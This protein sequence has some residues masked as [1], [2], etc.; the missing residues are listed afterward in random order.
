[1]ASTQSLL[2]QLISRNQKLQDDTAKAFRYLLQR[3]LPNTAGLTANATGPASTTLTV[4]PGLVVDG[5]VGFNSGA[6]IVGGRTYAFHAFLNCSGVGATGIVVD[7]NGGSITTTTFN[8]TGVGNAA[9]A[10]S[11]TQATTQAN[12]LF[13]TAAAVLSIVIDGTFTAASSGSFGLRIAAQNGTTA[14]VLFAGSYVTVTE[15]IGS[16]G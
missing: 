6:A 5:G 12:P 16:A 14:P 8:G 2:T 4:V 13:S 1:M 3:G 15:I 10:Q 7:G 9:A 11:T